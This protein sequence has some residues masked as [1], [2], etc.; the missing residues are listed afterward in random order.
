[1]KRALA[2]LTVALAL[3]CLVNQLYGETVYF[4]VAESGTAV[5]GDSY[6]LPLTEPNDIAHARDLIQNGPSAGQPIVVAQITC[7]YDC[8]NR[9]YLE[10]NH[11]IADPN[12]PFRRDK[13]AWSWH[14]T[15]FDYFADVTAEILDGWPGLVESDC[16]G[17]GSQIGFWTYTVVE[18][19][20]VDPAHWKR[21]FKG[22]STVDF[23][24]NAYIGNNWFGNCSSP[25]WCGGTDLDHNGEVDYDD[26]MI[27]AEAW[28]SPYASKPADPPIFYAWGLP[29]QCYGDADGKK[30]GPLGYRIYA[31]DFDV[32]SAC[33]AEC[34][35][36]LGGGWPCNYSTKG[37]DPRC[38]FNRDYKIYD[39]DFAILNANYKKKDS[40]FPTTC[41]PKTHCPGN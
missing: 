3:V 41:P 32:F 8:V 28:L 9:N 19:L 37:Y 30:T 6:V 13:R 17:F 1:M 7:S 35:G 39:D 40:D 18:E 2:I 22:D 36:L 38:D 24:D 12:G 33:M 21:D 31:T 27:F 4:L 25:G 29:Y 10:P 15:Q 5:H 14:V 26:L 23:V 20:G 16:A 34:K 11:F